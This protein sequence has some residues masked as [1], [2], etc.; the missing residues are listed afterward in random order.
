MIG[1]ADFDFLTIK[2][3]V[4]LQQN[5]LLSNPQCVLIQCFGTTAQKQ[6]RY[7]VADK[8]TSNNRG[9]IRYMQSSNLDVDHINTVEVSKSNPYGISLDSK[10]RLHATFQNPK[11]RKENVLIISN[12]FTNSPQT[13]YR[14]GIDVNIASIEADGPYKFASTDG[15]QSICCC[16][17]GSMITFPDR[18]KLMMDVSNLDSGL[19][20]YMKLIRCFQESF[21]IPDE[22]M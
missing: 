7:V 11:D 17:T 3:T 9:G 20:K 8:G 15:A 16:G 2:I 19:P 10:G 5:Q 21:C 13:I 6:Y 18:L 12:P 22:C 14:I 1:F 4:V